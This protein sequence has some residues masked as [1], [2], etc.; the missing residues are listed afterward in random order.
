[1]KS[2]QELGMTYAQLSPDMQLYIQAL[3]SDQDIFQNL[4][5]QPGVMYIVKNVGGCISNLM[6]GSGLETLI[7]P[8]FGGSQ[9]HHGTRETMGPC[10]ASI[11]DGILD[12]ATILLRN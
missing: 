4:I 5:L 9:Q 8:A 2:L 7:G 6:K 12:S 3:L 10:N 11:Q 1:M